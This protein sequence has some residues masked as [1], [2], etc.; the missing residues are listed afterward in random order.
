LVAYNDWINVLSS[1][2]DMRLMWSRSFSAASVG[3]VWRSVLSLCFGVSNGN[4]VVN[5]ELRRTTRTITPFGYC[6]S[7]EFLPEAVWSHSHCVNARWNRCQGL[8][9]FLLGELEETTRT[10]S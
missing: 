4:T 6:P 1:V 10:P 9:S 8:N 3:Y 7:M 2:V 5:D